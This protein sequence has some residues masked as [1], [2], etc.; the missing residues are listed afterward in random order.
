[1]E[2]NFQV[3]AWRSGWRPTFAK[4]LKSA[5]PTDDGIFNNEDL[6]LLLSTRLKQALIVT[7]VLLAFVVIDSLAQTAYACA[8][9]GQL[10]VKLWA[11]AVF[12]PLFGL[13]GFGRSILTALGD[14]AEGKRLGVPLRL[15]LGRCRRIQDGVAALAT[16]A[17]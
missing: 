1:M 16:G 9:L 11:M 17:G 6:R 7:G 13:A 12:A 4:Q 15:G 14:K 5:E 3:W 8:L 2:S 10:H